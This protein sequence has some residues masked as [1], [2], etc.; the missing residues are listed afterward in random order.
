[1]PLV[2]LVRLLVQIRVRRGAG[3]Q[4]KMVRVKELSKGGQD[5]ALLVQLKMEL[6]HAVSLFSQ[7]VCLSFFLMELTLAVCLSLFSQSLARSLSFS[8]SLSS[9]LFLS[10]SLFL[11]V[12][13]CVCVCVSVSLSVCL[14]LSL[15]LSLSLPPIVRPV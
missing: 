4:S 2:V 7:S 9:S 14:S 3:A 6:T 15:S 8:L 10:L 1:M 11:S 12:C 13:V 5:L